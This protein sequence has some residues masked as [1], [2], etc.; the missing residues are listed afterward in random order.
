MT[1][2][3]LKIYKS[4]IS[5]L[6]FIYTQKFHSSNQLNSNSSSKRWIQR[7]KNDY[8]T[9]EARVLQYKSRAAFK[10]LEINEKYKIF[11]PGNTVIDLGFSPGSWS[12]VAV[13]KVGS[14]GRVLGLDII[15]SQPPAG[16]S[17][18]QG[19]FLS[20][21]TQRAIIMYLSDPNR[22]RQSAISSLSSE[23]G[24][25]LSYIDLEKRLEQNNTKCYNSKVA[26]VILSDMLAPLPQIDGFYKRSLSDPYHRLA[27]VS[28][29]SVKDHGASMDL[30]DSAL[31]FCIDA[32]HVGGN[33]ICKFYSGI[34]DKILLKKMQK[35]FQEVKREKP[36]ASHSESRESYF[37]GLKMRAS[38]NK[39]DIENM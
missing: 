20:K 10:L 18:M 22:G 38:I 39:K 24:E 34:E 32:L 9:R 5:K 1:I 13:E 16:A 30:C 29:I 28:G 35:V 4:K 33:F 31:L 36:C 17:S 7:Q 3:N 25:K 37:I 14:K 23:N 6:F 8:F 15:P 27:N 21:A 2:L 11:K 26:D 12:Q 19:N